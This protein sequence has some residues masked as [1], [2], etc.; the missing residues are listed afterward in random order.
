MRRGALYEARL[1][2]DASAVGR[3]G[4]GGGLGP[5]ELCLDK[6]EEGCMMI[7]T[8]KN[9]Q[10]SSLNAEEVKGGSRVGLR[11]RGRRP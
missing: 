8:M 11:M 6:D 10:G 7:T 1:K 2:A 9:S 4:V 5:E 3:N